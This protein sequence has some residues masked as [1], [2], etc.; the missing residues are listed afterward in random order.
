[1]VFFSKK[2]RLFLFLAQVIHFLMQMLFFLVEGRARAKRRLHKR[3]IEII[4]A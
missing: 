2:L 4:V 3:I 1:M